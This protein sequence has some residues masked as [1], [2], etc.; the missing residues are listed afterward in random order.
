MET[1][2]RRFRCTT[3]VNPI[4]AA[5]L[6]IA[7]FPAAAHRLEMTPFRMGIEHFPSFSPRVWW[8]RF[9]VKPLHDNGFSRRGDYKHPCPC[10]YLFNTLYVLSDLRIRMGSQ[11]YTGEYIRKIQVLRL[12]LNLQ[13]VVIFSSI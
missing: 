4:D 6:G 11:I 1:V 5:S 13:E 2:P 7:R 3:D 12:L 8:K 10:E 9:S